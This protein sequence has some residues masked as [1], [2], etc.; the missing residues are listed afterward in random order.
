M[1]PVM[2]NGLA[3]TAATVTVEG[4][5]PERTLSDITAIIHSSELSGAEKMLSTR[6][7][8]R[9]ADAEAKVHGCAPAEVH[10]HEVGAVD[11]IVDIVGVACG[12]AL[13]GTSGLFCL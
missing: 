3:A 9:L 6:V 1:Q 13:L 8:E 11:A 7:F 2:K 5:S 4:E 12:L 10:F